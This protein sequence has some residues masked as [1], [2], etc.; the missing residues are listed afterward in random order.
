MST[1]QDSQTTFKLDLTW[2]FL[3]ARARYFVSNPDGWPC[4]QRMCKKWVVIK[5]LFCI[6]FS[7]SKNPVEYMTSEC[8][9]Y[10]ENIFCQALLPQYIALYKCHLHIFSNFIGLISSFPFLFKMIYI[11]CVNLFLKLR[12]M[13][14][15]RDGTQM[16]K[17][18]AN[19]A[20]SLFSK[21]RTFLFSW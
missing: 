3:S 15:L 16:Q 13:W 8:L 12:S 4:M 2:I 18:N 6:V 21:A 7:S 17:G 10:L 19:P 11:G 20:L 1:T 9:P 14:N 5:F